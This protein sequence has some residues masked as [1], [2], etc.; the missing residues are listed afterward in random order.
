[1]YWWR[2]FFRAEML[3]LKFVSSTRLSHFWLTPSGFYRPPLTCLQNIESPKNRDKGGKKPKIETAPSFWCY[4]FDLSANFFFSKS[5]SIFQV[6]TVNSDPVTN[7]RWKHEMMRT[8]FTSRYEIIKFQS[9]YDRCR[10]SQAKMGSFKA[11]MRPR[12]DTQNSFL[13]QLSRALR[14]VKDLGKNYI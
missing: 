10:W 3:F 7:N 11:I 14:N 9:W 8:L 12:L 13:L 2:T 6:I 4:H 1:M 5:Y